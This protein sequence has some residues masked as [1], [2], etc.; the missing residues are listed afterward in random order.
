MAFR[1]SP[2]YGPRYFLRTRSF[3]SPPARPFESAKELTFLFAG[4]SDYEGAIGKLR[5]PVSESHRRLDCVV[6]P[7]C[8]G[9]QAHDIAADISIRAAFQ[10]ISDTFIDGF[11]RLLKYENHLQEM[12][13]HRSLQLARPVGKQL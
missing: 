10:S 5:G 9:S 11:K 8:L 12:H 13:R 7:R 2:C 6:P 1:R 4:R 3:G